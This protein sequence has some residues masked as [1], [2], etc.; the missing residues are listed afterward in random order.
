MINTELYN[1]YRLHI[2]NLNNSSKTIKPE[3]FNFGNKD[4]TELLLPYYN[5]TSTWNEFFKAINKHFP[6][7]KCTIMYPWILRAINYIFEGNMFFIGNEWII[8]LNDNPTIRYYELDEKNVKHRILQNIHGGAKESKYKT[9]YFHWYHVN[10]YNTMNWDFKKYL[11][12]N[13]LRKT[14]KKT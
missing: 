3:Q 14:R 7:V 12:N 5:E 6:K 13:S 11:K 9:D 4:I 2:Q 1:K 10:N 8:N